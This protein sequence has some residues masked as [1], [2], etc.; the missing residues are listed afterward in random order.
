MKKDIYDF[1]KE[2]IINLKK[3][4][5]KQLAEILD[6]RINK[7]AWTT[8]SELFEELENI[9]NKASDSENLSSELKNQVDEILR[10]LEEYNSGL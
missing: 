10:M 3:E 6:H 9:L 1:L 7:V 2:L 8:S 4:D 5:Q